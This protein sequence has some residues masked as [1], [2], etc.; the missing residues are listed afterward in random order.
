MLRLAGGL[1]LA[2]TAA[3]PLG[4][5]SAE[6]GSV[7]PANGPDQTGGFGQAP[8]REMLRHQRRRTH[9]ATSQ[10]TI[11]SGVAAVPEGG[12]RETATGHDRRLEPS[13]VAIDST[14]LSR[15]HPGPAWPVVKG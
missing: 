15:R 7:L 10:A 14:P 9:V 12:A 8:T 4:M 5:T 2:A 6:A 13:S 3:L 1:A 11:R